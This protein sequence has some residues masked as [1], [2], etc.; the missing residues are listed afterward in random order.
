MRLLF[1]IDHL[2]SGGAQRQLVN[3]ALGLRRK[4]HHIEFF[5][6]HP[7]DFFA[8]VL[9][10]QGIEIHR[11]YK[12]SRYSTNVISRL[13]SLVRKNHYDVMVSFLVTPNFYAEL[14]RL[15]C[16]SRPPK[17]IVS[18]RICD[19]S[20]S[21]FFH[22]RV[23]RQFHRLADR[24]TV[25]SYHHQSDLERR[26]SW[27]QNKITAIYNGIDL[28]AFYPDLLPKKMGGGLNFLAVASISERKNGLRL[29]QAL[30][31]VRKKYHIVPTV[32]WVGEH[33]THLPERRRTSSRWKEEVERLNLQKQWQWHDPRN[34]IAQLMRSFDALIHPSY[35]E[36]LPN[37]VCEALASGL[38]ALVSNMQ[39]NPRLVS[40]G[41]SGFLFDPHS[42]E[43]IAD[44][45]YRFSALD[46]TARDKMGAAG[47]AFAEQ[48]LGLATFVDHYE[49]V[50][51]NLLTEP[52]SLRQICAC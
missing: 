32:H 44:A 46:H 28:G 27:L 24:V 30:D 35:V 42:A 9:A 4:N 51:L 47:R 21:R 36:G 22:T 5:V 33:Q 6:Y 18:E 1:V 12:S 38:P 52:D 26:F 11:C 20:E 15:F 3:L 48:R 23:L 8:G 34:D 16:G 31:I 17:L 49:T 13:T 37:V 45:I 40:D 41:V 19:S 25:N 7:H 39:D 29:I 50:M 43:S 14:A 2:N 10:E